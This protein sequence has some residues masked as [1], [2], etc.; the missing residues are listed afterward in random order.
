MINADRYGAEPKTEPIWRI[1]EAGIRKRLELGIPREVIGDVRIY[2]SI[3]SYGLEVC[4]FL[5]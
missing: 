1:D 5:P 3:L 4:G 2:D